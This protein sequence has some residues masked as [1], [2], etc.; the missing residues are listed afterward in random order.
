MPTI[1]VEKYYL[2]NIVEMNE[3]GVT[4]FGPLILFLKQDSLKIPKYC[5]ILVYCTVKISKSIAIAP[6]LLNVE[7]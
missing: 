2:L 3:E 7:R 5:V 6:T 4:P 1:C